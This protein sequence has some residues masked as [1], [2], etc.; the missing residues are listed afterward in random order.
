MSP[1]LLAIYPVTMTASPSLAARLTLLMLVIA[2]AIGVIAAPAVTAQG[3]G[4]AALKTVDLPQGNSH[5]QPFDRMRY[6]IGD[7]DN[8]DPAAV[9]RQRADFQPVTTP[10]LDFGEKD[11][12]IWLIM[13]VRNPSDRAGDWL[14]DIQRPFADELLVAKLDRGSVSQTLLYID[15]TTPFSAR[16]VQSQYLVA[17]LFMEAGETAEILIGVRSSTGSWMPVTFATQERMRTAHMQ[18]ARFNWTINGAIL[19]LVIAALFM[20]RLAGWPLALGFAGYAGLGA[21]LVANIEGY[22]HRF[23]LTEAMWAH[24]PITIILIPAIML[25]LLQFAFVFADLRKTAPTMAGFV[26]WMQAGLAV[27]IVI[28]ATGWQFAPVQRA[29]FAAVPAVS[30]TYLAIAVIALRARVLGAIPFLAGSAVIALTVAVM[31]AML[32][33]PGQ[34]PLT[35]ALDYFHAALLFESFAFFIAIV[36]RMLAMQRALNRS[37]A[38][39][40]AA[41]RE[42][43]ELAYALQDSRSRY[44]AARR[45]AEAMRGRLQSAS[46]DLQQPMIALRQNVERVAA[47]DGEAAGKLESALDYL[48]AITETGLL[49]V[50]EDDTALAGIAPDEGAETFPLSVALEN[51]SA[52]FRSEA[53]SAGTQLISKPT[54]LSVHTDPV[55]LMRAVSNLVSNALK[56][57]GAGEITLEAAQAGEQT[58]IRI[59]DNG[60][61]MSEAEVAE[62]AKPHVKGADSDGHGL[63]LALVRQFAARLGHSLEIRS[64][65]GEGTLFVLGVPAGG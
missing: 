4:L 64:A 11:V 12:P 19:A 43:L 63:G 40:V 8:L 45:S 26:R 25:A 36:V 53:E 21:V 58:E 16:P 57:A 54:D 32:L 13:Q 51:C 24:E 60:I 27:M 55:D 39:E 52:M 56:H 31:A 44:D 61:G 33:M 41:T 15:K 20:G 35:I 3:D 7:S 65:P 6:L 34:L 22:L 46:H 28:G 42:K 49:E 62:F 10:W 23:I 1:A 5:V 50:P 38:L 9:L 18:E 30:L 2:A 59:S 48:E 17:P 47:R 37:L 29:I 14:L